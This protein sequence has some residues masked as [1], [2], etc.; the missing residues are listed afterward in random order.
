[1]HY[2]YHREEEVREDSFR[3]SHI[4]RKSFEHPAFATFR[5]LF[6]DYTLCEQAL[7]V[8]F[9][10]C[11]A[12]VILAHF[13]GTIVHIRY[14]PLYDFAPINTVFVDLFVRWLLNEPVGDTSIL[15]PPSEELKI[16]EHNPPKNPPAELVNG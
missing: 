9:V 2:R 8:S 7:M 15:Q 3:P 1:M 11:K 4:P 13:D 6:S 5:G 16:E 10:G 12:R 14:S